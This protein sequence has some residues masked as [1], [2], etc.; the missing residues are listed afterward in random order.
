MVI[1]MKKIKDYEINLG[2]L[3]MFE[4]MQ[5]LVTT[6]DGLLPTDIIKETDKLIRLLVNNLPNDKNI[7]DNYDFEDDIFIQRITYKKIK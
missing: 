3:V 6:Y 7:P 2:V 4:T 5:A 1:K